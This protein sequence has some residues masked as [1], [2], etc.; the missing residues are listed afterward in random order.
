MRV[1]QD[2]KPAAFADAYLIYTVSGQER[3]FVLSKAISVE[4]V[5][6]AWGSDPYVSVL[7]LIYTVDRRGQ[8]FFLR[9]LSI[10]IALFSMRL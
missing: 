7:F 1:C 6:S 4:S 2:P 10:N 8:A 5:Q 9:N 3:I